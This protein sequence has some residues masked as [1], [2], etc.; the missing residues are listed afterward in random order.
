MPEPDPEPI[1]ES[2]PE[3]AAAA[4]PEALAEAIAEV[5][6]EPAV[7]EDDLP[8][9]EE[10]QPEAA[11]EPPVEVEEEPAP[12]AAEEE[13][14]SDDDINEMLG[15]EE[16]VAEVSSLI[17]GSK[18]EQTEFDPDDL[19]EEEPIPEV[20][21]S[22][23]VDDDDEDYDIGGGSG[24]KRKVLVILL[25]V[26]VVLGGLGA[27]LY[28]LRNQIVGLMPSV[29]S[30]YHMVGIEV[31]QL[32]GGLELI[33]VRNEFADQGQ[34]RLVV[35]G[36]IANVSDRV[37]PVPLLKIEFRDEDNEVVQNY[38]YPPEATELQPGERIEFKADVGEVVRTARRVDVTFT[39]EMPGEG[40]GQQ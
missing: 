9:E 12:Q 26:L 23:D 40:G 2:E 10:L 13:V 16:D 32:G 6:T 21:T 1:P 35:S 19:P 4:D 34:E 37:R 8:A 28:F 29:A 25:I 22:R 7:E 33:D 30:A 18:D 14:L 5:I 24:S 27:G 36:T 3:E 20:F 11:E 17:N 38:I 15:P 31:E 39:D